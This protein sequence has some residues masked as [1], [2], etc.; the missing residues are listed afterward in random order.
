L[1][2]TRGATKNPIAVFMACIAVVVLSVIA[3][4]RLPRDLFPRITVPVIVVSAQ[5][6]GAT[7]ETMERTVTYPLE[8]A[9][10][11]V[12]GVQQILSTTRTGTTSIQVWFDWGTNLNIA[13]VEVI[14]NVQR[15]MRSLPAGVTQPFVLKFDISNIPVAQVVVGGGGLDARQLYDLGYNTIEPQLERIPGVSQA[16]VNGGL[17]RQLN[18]NVDPNKLVATGLTLQ[19]VISGISRYNALIPSGDL[20]NKRI[21]YQLNVPSLLQSVPAIQNVVLAT[22][23]GVPIH[24]ADVAQVQDAAADQ[25]QIVRINGKPGVLMF[26][27]REPDANAI[28]VVDALRKAL[29]RLSG[30]PKGVTLQIGFDQSQ[31][32][33]AAIATLQREAVIGAVLIFLVVLVFLR[34]LWSLVIIGLG[35]PLS[36]STALLLLYFTGQSLNIFTLGGL[37]LAMGRLVDDAIVVRENITRH[38]TVPGTPVLQAVIEAT[39]E[40]GLPVLASTA[41]TI[42]VFFP[43]VFLSGIS[44]RLFV[45]MAL[46]IVFALGAS[47]VVSMTIDPVLSLKFLRSS[48]GTAVEGHGVVARFVRWSERLMEGLDERY[49]QA[50]RWTLQHASAA[51]AGIALI[52][53]LS[54][55]A[56]RGIGTE[57]FPDTDESQFSVAVQVPQG[58]AVQQAS[59]VVEQ[60][61]NV[62]R[63]VIPAK[64]YLAVYTNTGV[65]SGGF[66]SNSGPNYGEVEIRLVPP[67][68]RHRSSTDWSNA[69]RTA[70]NGKFPGVLMFVNVGGLEH[71]IV[72]VGAAAPIDIQLIGY[73]QQVGAQ[74]AQQV[75]AA[76]GGI[77][78]TADVQIT[79][80]GQ[81]PNFNVNVDQE[82]A[83]QLGISSTDI[84]NAVN[85]A[86]AG[87][88]A[89]ASQFIDPVTGNEY[90]IVVKL[91]DAYR[92]HPEDLGGVPL[93]VLA[94]P[95]AGASTPAG[96]TPPV[97][98]VL[99]RDVARITLGSQ[100]LQI[101]RKNEQ[102]V[103]DVTANV[104]NRPLGAVSQDVAKA[105]DRM[106]FPEGFTYHMAGQTEQ[107]QGAFSSLGFALV[108]ALMLVYMIMASQFMSLVDPFIIMFAVPLG[109]IGV[110]WMLLLTHTTLSIISFMGVITMIGVVVSNGILLVDYANKMQERGM[111]AQDAVLQAGRIR[112]RPILMTAIATI[113]AM[114][115]MATGL[116][117]GSETNMPLARA[118]IGGLTVSTGLT[119]LL[120]PVLYVFF[121]RLLPR[122]RRTEA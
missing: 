57:F 55:L 6:S 70:L 16:F 84:A 87:N 18:V 61:A 111:S 22:R 72:N 93:N 94:D 30:L 78:G 81:Y 121:E 122:R 59:D 65:N 97:V 52:F 95:P 102:R 13:E 66:G 25:T 58:T 67:T 112:L 83:A 68:M 96:T 47:Y 34:S 63:K 14:Q 15:V 28:Q 38:L 73:N 50:L 113:I 104:I 5:Y 2:L 117:E 20:K 119:L 56:A 79:P 48:Q 21:D 120:I 1:F 51:V 115:P 8:Q 41:S 54:M 24:V 49:Q 85:T 80:R 114:I 69:V 17:V 26:V 53:V 19:N 43:I 12:A 9:V 33:R 11:R 110:I 105:L 40:V 45:P 86:M 89:T 88:V 76:V 77:E 101:G 116:G 109:F 74:F 31:Y 23:N 46:T 44:Q 32:I 98:P 99:L 106:P 37:T 64:D 107:Q 100:P 3:L 10:T 90:N 7:P 29:P 118:V 75:A 27:A 82:K 62:V 92:T 108:L 36:V 4:Q 39:Q 35:V 103:I 71:R 91:Q 42:A 60:V